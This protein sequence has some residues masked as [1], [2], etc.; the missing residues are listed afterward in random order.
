[1]HIILLCAHLFVFLIQFQMQCDDAD[2]DDE[3][4]ELQKHF[5]LQ[6]LKVETIYIFF[7]FHNDVIKFT[8]CMFQWTSDSIK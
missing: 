8:Y 3:V 2:D 4:I 5:N 1:M 7:K 6:S